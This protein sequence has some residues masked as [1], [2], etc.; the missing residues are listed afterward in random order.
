MKTK[1]TPTLLFPG[2]ANVLRVR[3]GSLGPPPSFQ[4]EI[5]AVD[6]GEPE[7]ESF[8]AAKETHRPRSEE[9]EFAFAILKAVNIT[10]TREQW[11]NWAEGGDAASDTAYILTCITDILGYA[12]PP[13]QP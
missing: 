12:I 2:T 8:V 9:S 3:S 7:I 11:D 5:I 6:G 13:A 4:V 1:I 10:M